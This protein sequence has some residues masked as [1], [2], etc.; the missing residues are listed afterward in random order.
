MSELLTETIKHLMALGATH[1]TPQGVKTDNGES[2]PFVVLPKDMS[3]HNLKDVFPPQRIERRVRFDEA[4]SFCAYLNRFKS[5]QTQIWCTVDDDLDAEFI[6]IL[7]YHGPAPE[8]RPA[9]CRHFAT[10]PVIQTPEWKAITNSNRRNFFQV[11]FAAWLEDNAKLC[12]SPSG[13]DLLELVRDLHGHRNARF[14]TAIRLDNGAYS[15]QFDEDIV[16]KGN[17][18]TKAGEMELPREIKFKAAVFLGGEQFEILARLKT[19]CENRSLVLFY[20]IAN[21]NEIRRESLLA[22]VKQVEKETKI[23]PYLGAP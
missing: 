2:D 15:V 8:L 17:A 4:G 19:R 1:T 5:P 20:E 16:I 13:A 9:A 22:L 23:L 10:Y 3:V 21:L 7:D 18:T 12:L 6:A 11:E 14:N